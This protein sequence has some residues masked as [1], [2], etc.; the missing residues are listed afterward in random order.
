MEINLFKK[1]KSRF[2]NLSPQQNPNLDS[3]LE[4]SPF[5]GHFCQWFTNMLHKITEQI[6]R[7]EVGQYLSCIHGIKVQMFILASMNYVFLFQLN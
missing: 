6:K 1:N 5:S 4:T 3:R 7:Q 2:S